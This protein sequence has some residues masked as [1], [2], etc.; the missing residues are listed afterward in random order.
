MAHLRKQ[1]RDYAAILLSGYIYNRFG[2][3][4]LDR[5][6]NKIQPADEIVPNGSIYKSRH[7][8]LDD[9][10]LPAIC[11]YT[12]SAS[13][14]LVTIGERVLEHTLELRV[15]VIDKGASGSIFENAEQFAAEIVD[16]I[17]SDESMGGL[18]KDITLT[19]MDTDVGTQG[20]RAM[21]MSEL[22]FEV[23]YRTAIN[24]CEVS[25]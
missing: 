20:E 1:I 6:N 17:L 5:S 4:L 15:D 16:A 10:K 23:V 13:S 11:V 18:V 2:I 19:S 7:Y 9:A 25:V 14:A 22:R 24:N 21:G 8:A 3:V 12:E